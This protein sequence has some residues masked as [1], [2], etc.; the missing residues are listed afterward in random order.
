MLMMVIPRANTRLWTQ[1]Q[2]HPSDNK[3][4]IGSKKKNR[5][6]SRKKEGKDGNWETVLG[7]FKELH[8]LEF[9]QKNLSEFQRPKVNRVEVF[10]KDTN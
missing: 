6:I 4:S 7:V 8:G 5:E 9:F 3:I 10:C 1:S 2:Q